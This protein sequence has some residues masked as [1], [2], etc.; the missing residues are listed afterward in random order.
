MNLNIQSICENINEN[1]KN[2]IVIMVI[3]YIIQLKIVQII[4]Q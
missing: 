1:F 2:L 3:I 4:F